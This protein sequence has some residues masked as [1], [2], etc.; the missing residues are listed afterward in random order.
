MARSTASKPRPLRWQIPGRLRRMQAEAQLRGL[1]W[2]KRAYHRVA[3]AG[4][5]T[6]RKV[7]FIFGCQRSGTTLMLDIFREDLRTVVFPEVSELS[8]PEGGRLRLRPTPEIRAHIEQL[9]A[10]VVV[11]KPIVESQ[12]APRLLDAFQ[13]ASGIWMYRSYER[14]AFSD[15][16][17]FGLENG[18][19][20]LDLLLSNVPP[21]WRAEFVPPSTRKVLT[22]FYRPDMPPYD[23]AALFWWARNS[24]VFDLDLDKRKDVLLCRYEELVGDAERT[25]RG[26]YASVGVEWPRRQ[27]TKRVHPDAQTGNAPPQITA[28]VAAICDELLERLAQ[29]RHAGAPIPLRP[30]TATTP[31][32]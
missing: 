13:G 30:M 29:G 16:K 24:L 3:R 8:R 15:L 9:Q 32:P 17:L 25:M 20:N 7:I 22:R 19:R 10:P 18:I 27:I 26:V 2:R 31:R 6:N 28:D 14:V 23:A 1:E 11:L 4:S 5:R 12:N 21:N